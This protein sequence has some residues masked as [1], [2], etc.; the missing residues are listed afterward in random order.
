MV[1]DKL[2]I[3]PSFLLSGSFSPSGGSPSERSISM[4]HYW[5][6]GGKKKKKLKNV[7]IVTVN[8]GGRTSETVG[9]SEKLVKIKTNNIFRKN[10]GNNV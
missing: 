2:F 9:F 4:L 6:N 5:N 3:L 8:D 10:I 7:L 1:K